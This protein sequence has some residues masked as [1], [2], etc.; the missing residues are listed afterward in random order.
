[1]TKIKL[2]PQNKAVKIKP[3]LPRQRNILPQAQEVNKPTSVEDVLKMADEGLASIDKDLGKPE[4]SQDRK[5]PDPAAKNKIS[6]NFNLSF[7][8]SFNTSFTNGK[9]KENDSRNEPLNNSQENRLEFTS[10]LQDDPTA[11]K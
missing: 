6:S 3:P 7:N 8:N 9:G 11:N 10:Q 2:T 1:L 5:T 4:S